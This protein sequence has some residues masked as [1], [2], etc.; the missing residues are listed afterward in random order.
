MQR[1]GRADDVVMYVHSE[2]GRRVPENTSLGT[3]HGTAQVNFVI[4]NGVKGGMYGKPPSLSELVL[5]DNLQSTID[6]R[7]VYATLIKEWLGADAT[8]VLGQPF[9]TLGM[10]KAQRAEKPAT[11]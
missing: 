9:E 8:T 2:F 11:P 10:I 3:D 7:R 5:G 4:G 6:F 1:I